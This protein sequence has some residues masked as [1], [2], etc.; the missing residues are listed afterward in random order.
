MERLIA[1]PIPCDLIEKE[2]IKRGRPAAA[3]LD[4]GFSK[5]ADYTFTEKAADR[6]RGERF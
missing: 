2:R 3:R 6:N 5:R 4:G 1:N